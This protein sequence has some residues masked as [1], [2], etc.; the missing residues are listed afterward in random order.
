MICVTNSTFAK[1]SVRNHLVRNRN[2]PRRR[3]RVPQHILASINFVNTMRHTYAEYYML[4][5]GLFQ[6]IRNI[7]VYS[8]K[9]LGI[10]YKSL[11]S[12][13]ECKSFIT[14]ADQTTCLST[15]YISSLASRTY[16][17]LENGTINRKMFR[18]WIK[19]WLKCLWVT[20]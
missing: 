2:L 7:L 9:A 19:R 18:V 16:I 3:I 1:F 11:M 12:E 8:I 17:T 10:P 15:V 4:Y 13:F 6:M 5:S 20:L 14:H